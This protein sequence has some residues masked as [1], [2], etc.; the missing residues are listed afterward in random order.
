MATQ[1]LSVGFQAGVEANID[2][3]KCEG[4]NPLF[5]SKIVKAVAK[6]HVGKEKEYLLKKA[7]KLAKEGV[8]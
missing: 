4:H 8:K 2:I 1:K 3:L 6:Q 5:I 7:E